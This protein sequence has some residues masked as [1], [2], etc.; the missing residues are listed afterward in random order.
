M[1][2]LVINCSYPAAGCLKMRGGIVAGI[3]AVCHC[4]IWLIMYNRYR[5]EVKQLNELLSKTK[6]S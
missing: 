3:F 4:I 5:S 2:G 6:T 1:S